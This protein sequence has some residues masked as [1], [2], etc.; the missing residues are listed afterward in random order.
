MKGESDIAHV[1]LKAL[2]TGMMYHLMG[3]GE[4]IKKS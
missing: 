3:M 4:R 2:Q 1:V